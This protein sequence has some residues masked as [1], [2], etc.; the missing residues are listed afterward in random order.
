MKGPA[1]GPSER[2]THTLSIRYAE[3]QGREAHLDRF[4]AFAATH[5][6]E[7]VEEHSGQVHSTPESLDEA[8]AA[9]FWNCT[10]EELATRRQAGEFDLP[11]VLREA[12]FT[13]CPIINTV[14]RNADGDRQIHLQTAEGNSL[15]CIGAWLWTQGRMV[16]T[17]GFVTFTA[18]SPEQ[19]SSLVDAYRAEFDT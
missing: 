14:Y 7:K 9:I 12:L 19:L 5:G 15:P 4:A 18:D 10:P 17:G 11:E 16:L 6:L 3:G 1:M 13:P 8:V 2:P